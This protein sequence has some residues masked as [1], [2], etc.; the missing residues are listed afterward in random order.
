MFHAFAH[1]R[2]QNRRPGRGGTYT[3]SHSSQTCG[4]AGIADRC[5]S[6]QSRHRPGLAARFGV[7]H[8]EQVPAPRFRRHSPQT[9][10]WARARQILRQIEHS[11]LV[12][13]GQHSRFSLEMRQRPLSRRRALPNPR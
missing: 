8:C 2:E 13:R 9:G 1:D 12:M 4:R 6:K 3:H 11:A 7:P 10:R 5:L